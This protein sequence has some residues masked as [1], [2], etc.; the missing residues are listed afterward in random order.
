MAVYV[1]TKSHFQSLANNRSSNR[2]VSFVNLY[3]FNF[4]LPAAQ[5]RGR[6]GDS[7]RP[8]QPRCAPRRVTEEG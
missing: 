3:F 1:G 6:L 5:G 8:Q 7:I 2:Q 4:S